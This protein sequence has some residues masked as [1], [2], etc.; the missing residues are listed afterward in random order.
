MN[1]VEI[2]QAVPELADQPFD[3]ERGGTG[4]DG[5]TWPSVR[6]PGGHCIAAFWPN[7]IPIPTGV[8]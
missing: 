4:S 1:A 8:R 2:E 3:A 7:V 6:S 5:I